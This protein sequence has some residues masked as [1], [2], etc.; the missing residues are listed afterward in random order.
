M[1]FVLFKTKKNNKYLTPSRFSARLVF[2]FITTRC[3]QNADSK[4]TIL[5]KA[6]DYILLLEDEIRKY[7]AAYPEFEH[8]EQNRHGRRHSTSFSGYESEH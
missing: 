4:A 5:R 7:A 3:A 6:V 1:K 8:A 2:L